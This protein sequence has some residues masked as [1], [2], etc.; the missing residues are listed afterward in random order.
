MNEWTFL[1]CNM[2]LISHSTRI[3]TKITNP[4]YDQAL[5]SQAPR[6]LSPALPLMK[7]L[8]NPHLHRN[9]CIIVAIIQRSYSAS[10][11]FSGLNVMVKSSNQIEWVSYVSFWLECHGWIKQPNWTSFVGNFR[12]NYESILCLVCKRKKHFCDILY[13]MLTPS[14]ICC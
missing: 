14:W 12:S 9:I 3:G 7:F 2:T 10:S 8:V 13:M 6:T 4:N 11:S 1:L 5:L